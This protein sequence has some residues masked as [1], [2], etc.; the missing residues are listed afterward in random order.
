M[1]TAGHTL[2]HGKTLFYY[3]TVTVGHIL[4]HG[5]PILYYIT[6]T[7]GHTLFN[8]KPLPHYITVVVGYQISQ[9]TNSTVTVFV[10]PLSEQSYTLD[11][12]NHR[13]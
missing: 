7:V 2:Y 1:V 9:Y 8:C 3:I 11:R 13:V 5:K 10:G 6:V 4:Y 12:H